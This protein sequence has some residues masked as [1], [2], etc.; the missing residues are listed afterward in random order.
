LRMCDSRFY[1]A[2]SATIGERE[3]SIGVSCDSSCLYILSLN[4]K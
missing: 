3:D 2:K 1:R 4:L